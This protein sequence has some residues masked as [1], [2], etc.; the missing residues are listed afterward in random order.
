MD[1]FSAVGF[2][3][4]IITFV[5]FSW[6]LIKG[7]CEVYQSLSGQTV[8]NAC[9]NDVIADL[10][11]VSEDLDG[12]P[13]GNSKHARALQK[14]AAMCLDLSRDLMKLLKELKRGERKNSVWRSLQVKWMSMRKA[15][16]VESLAERLSEYRSEI[17]LRLSLMLR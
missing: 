6:K 12:A 11:S 13:T 15:G 17:M 16:E 7:T 5:D 10:R 4:T 1:P 8:E 9:L 3:G 2:A 14:L